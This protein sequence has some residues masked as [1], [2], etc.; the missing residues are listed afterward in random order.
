MDVLLHFVEVMPIIF[1]SSCYFFAVVVRLRQQFS[2]SLMIS[3]APSV[4]PPSPLI[5]HSLS[6]VFASPFFTQ[7]SLSIRFDYE[8][9][10]ICFTE[11]KKGPLPVRLLLSIHIF[12]SWNW[13]PLRLT[14]HKAS[15]T[16]AS[17]MFI[18]LPLL[19]FL[20]H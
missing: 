19:F 1:S 10:V 5:S 20:R 15:C 18:V 12:A 17:V 16:R 6:D 13:R 3:N 11:R 9:L 4:L 14:A 8:Q 7:S 2:E